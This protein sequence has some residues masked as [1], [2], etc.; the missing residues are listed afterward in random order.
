MLRKEVYPAMRAYTGE[1]NQIKEV[2]TGES[3]FKDE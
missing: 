2:S 1:F 3:Y